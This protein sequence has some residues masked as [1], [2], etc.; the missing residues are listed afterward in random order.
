[1]GQRRNR[2][3]GNATGNDQLEIIE[4]GT[5]IQGKAMGGHAARNVNADGGNLGLFFRP[6]ASQAGNALSH[7]AQIA[8]ASDKHFLHFADELDRANPGSEAA[9]IK[10]RIADKLTGPVK[11]H[12]AT[13]VGLKQLDSFAVQ[14]IARGDDVLLTGITAQGD[15]RR[16][17][18]QQQGGPD[19]A[20]FDKVNER[21]LKLKRGG[22]IHPAQKDDVNDSHYSPVP[23]YE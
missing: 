13:A 16:M 10:N 14:K 18:E 5:H 7:Y 19:P 9:Q 8:A 2:F 23:L 15:D 4:I 20:F 22:I 21:L 1:M 12:V 11:G 17:F 6:H 3:I